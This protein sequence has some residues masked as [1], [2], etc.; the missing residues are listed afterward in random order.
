MRITNKIIHNNTVKNIH[1]SLQRLEKNYNQLSTGKR[2]N[3]PSDDPVGLVIAMKLKN[4]IREGEQFKKNAETAVGW[5][6]GSDAALDEMTKVLHTLKEIAVLGANGANPDSSMTA[7][8]DQVQQIRDHLL[9]IAN[10]KQEKRYL[11]AGQQSLQAPYSAAFTYQGDLSPMV[12]EIGPGTRMEVSIPGE[13]IFGDLGAGDFF[14]QLQQLEN[15]LRSSNFSAVSTTGLSMIEER[16]D[17]VLV[18]RSEI[19]AKVNRLETAVERYDLMNVN[20]KGLLSKEED[21]DIA[22]VTMNMKMK[23]NVYQAALATS[24]RIIQNTL[25]NYL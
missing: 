14:T 9:Q 23:E 24:A 8:A 6:Q 10:T 1:D 16:L 5:L 4:G 3:Y 17:N 15:D 22:E 11:F 19:G 18:I 25:V 2:I 20:L 7:L 21:A 13:R 12:M